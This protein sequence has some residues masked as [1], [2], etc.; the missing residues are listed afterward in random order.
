MTGSRVCEVLYKYEAKNTSKLALITKAQNG[1]N[2]DSFFEL[3]EISGINKESLAN[4]LNLSLK[5]FNR[6]SKENKKLNPVNSEQILKFF[7]LYNKGIEIFGTINSFNKWLHKP[8]YGLGSIK[9]Y[10]F[11]C[12]ISGIDLIYNELINIEFGD[13]S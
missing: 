1:L 4:F 5:T 12:T 9:P 10:N 7:M 6:Y 8:S 3:A 13:F 11:L 2:A